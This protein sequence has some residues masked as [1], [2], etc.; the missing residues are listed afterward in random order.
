MG[1]LWFARRFGKVK[2]RGRKLLAR[3]RG[4]LLALAQKLPIVGKATRAVEA[5]LHQSKA[6]EGEVMEGFDRRE[7]AAGAGLSQLSQLEQK[8]K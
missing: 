7:A 4:K 1:S 8:V 3:A 6:M 2:K 5:G